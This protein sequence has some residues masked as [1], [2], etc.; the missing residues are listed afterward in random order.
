MIPNITR[1]GSVAGV[2]AYLAGP[3]NENEHEHPELLMA[4]PGV[5]AES[6]FRVVPIESKRNQKWLT[7]AIDAP[8][9]A[10]GRDVRQRDKTTGEMKDAHVWH[11][12]LTLAP[13]EQLTPAQWQQAGR[14]FVKAMKYDACE[15]AMVRHGKTGRD[16]L[17]HVHLV[18]NLVQTESGKP[19]SVHNDFSRAQ[20]ACA[21]LSRQLGLTELQGQQRHLPERERRPIAPRRL[22]QGVRHEIVQR[23]ERAE[24]A[25]AAAGRQMTVEDLAA[26][27]V[28]QRITR[29]GSTLALAERRDVA[30]PL[31]DINARIDEDNAAIK[32]EQDL[33]AVEQTRQQQAPAPSPQELTNAQLDELLAAHPEMAEEIE[34]YRALQEAQRLTRISTPT[35]IEDA[36]AAGNA[37]DS[38]ERPRTGGYQPPGRDSGIGR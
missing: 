29:R 10:W 24:H 19:A 9:I 25:A 6:A 3:G 4:S 31:S 2:I 5:V 7:N 34:A 26:V 27:G 8:R 17:E 28:A 13:G 36:R 18:V 1:G 14:Q 37:E 33:A 32:H 20:A 16:Q 30:V 38:P 12:S 15:W 11:C 22:R 35:T 21:K 23:F